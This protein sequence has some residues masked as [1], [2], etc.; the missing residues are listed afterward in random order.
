MAGGKAGGEM[1][2]VE[3]WHDDS[4]LPAVEKIASALRSLA[5]R[6]IDSFLKNGSK[7]IDGIAVAC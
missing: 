2:D 3:P 5:A 4:T 6:E 7:W 1:A